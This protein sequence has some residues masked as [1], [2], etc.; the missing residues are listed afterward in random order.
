[1]H[2][3]WIMLRRS[4]YFLNIC[5]IRV[6]YRLIEIGCYNEEEEE[7]GAHLHDDPV[8]HEQEAGEHDN[9]RWARIQT[10]IQRIS[11]EQQ[12]QGAEISGLHG[13]VQRGNRMLEENNRMLLMMMQHLNLQDPPTDPN[14]L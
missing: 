6:F 5:Y 4:V 9:D 13:D 10:E 8:H 11:T 12:R 7:E 14:K 3:C 2:V 1:M